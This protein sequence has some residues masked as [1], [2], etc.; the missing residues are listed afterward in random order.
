MLAPGNV[1]GVAG[2]SLTELLNGKF[3]WNN[4]VK[5]TT[6]P[7]ASGTNGIHPADD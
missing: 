7:V 3:T 4:P 2:Q 5:L 6:Q 1:I